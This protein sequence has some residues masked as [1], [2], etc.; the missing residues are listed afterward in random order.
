MIANNRFAE[1]ELAKHQIAASQRWGF[2]FVRGCPLSQSEIYLWERVPPTNDIPEMY[3]LTRAAH[4]R[5]SDDVTQSPKSNRRHHRQ[6]S[7]IDLLDDRAEQSNKSTSNMLNLS[8]EDID[9]QLSEQSSCDEMSFEESPVD[10]MINDSV[11]TRTRSQ[12]SN[13]FAEAAA[14]AASSIS[15]TMSA[16]SSTSTPGSIRSSPRN[17]EKRQPKITGKFLRPFLLFVFRA[18]PHGICSINDRLFSQSIGRHVWI[19]DDR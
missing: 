17:R 2:D 19:F 18:L 1:Q 9:G 4:V 3:T 11:G 7:Y 10:K 15:T 13:A 14:S 8:F 6:S 5:Q 16:S 12:I